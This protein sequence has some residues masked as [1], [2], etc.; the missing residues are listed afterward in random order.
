M[1]TWRH[2]GQKIA[3]LTEKELDMPVTILD[4]SG[5]YF[6]EDVEVEEFAFD[7]ITLEDTKPLLIIGLNNGEA[8]NSQSDS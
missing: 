4:F 2:L 5:E 3:E 1:L 6:D 8:D 7:H